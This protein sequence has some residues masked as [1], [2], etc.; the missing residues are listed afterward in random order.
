[1]KIKEKGTSWKSGKLEEG[2]FHIL[3][4]KACSMCKWCIEHED[5]ISSLSKQFIEGTKTYK[6]DSI[7]HH[8]SS[9][10]H[11][12]AKGFIN[13][14]EKDNCVKM[15]EHLSASREKFGQVDFKSHLPEWQ[16]EILTKVTPCL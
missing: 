6:L 5:T 3:M 10:P 8:E 1:M 13:A 4:R 14:K 7:K 9:N 12:K 11:I 15:H 2:G 16:V